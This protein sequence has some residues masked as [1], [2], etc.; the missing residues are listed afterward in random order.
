MPLQRYYSL[1]ALYYLESV[2]SSC[3]VLLFF[4]SLLPWFWVIFNI[5]LCVRDSCAGSAYLAARWAA[6]WGLLGLAAPR[7]PGHQAAG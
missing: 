4:A 1:Q 3:R 5:L 6:A 7:R 2:Q